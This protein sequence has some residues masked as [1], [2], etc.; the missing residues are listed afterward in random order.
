MS[1]IATSGHFTIWSEECKDLS[2]TYTHT[3]S[4]SLSLSTS[5]SSCLLYL[6]LSSSPFLPLSPLFLSTSLSSSLLYLL[7]SSSPFLPLSPLYLSLPLLSSLPPSLFLFPYPHS[8]SILLP[9][10]I[11]F[12]LPLSLPSFL[13]P[14]PL[15]FS[16]ITSR[17]RSSS[18]E[19]SLLKEG[20]EAHWE[21]CNVYLWQ[22]IHFFPSIP[23]PFRLWREYCSY[24]AK[25][26]KELDMFRY[27]SLEYGW[28]CTH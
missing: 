21:V 18:E 26:T 20:D 9:P 14:S 5:L 25:Q 7:L 15:F 11:H 10:S 22:N 12:S 24:T 8:P 23:P 2:D 3:L 6:P 17:K 1:T 16:Q 19:F 28:C 13:P 4:L 27:I